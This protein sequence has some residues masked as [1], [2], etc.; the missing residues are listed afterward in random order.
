M[1]A[2]ITT[3][4][5]AIVPVTSSTLA[6]LQPRVIEHKPMA[7]FIA[8]ALAACGSESE[9]T[10]RAYRRAW[11]DFL[12]YVSDIWG[13]PRSLAQEEKVKRA[14]GK[15][16]K[17]LWAYSG[18]TR[19]F[20]KITPSLR[21]G[22]ISAMVGANLAR[23]TRNQRK[24]AVNTLLALA[25]RDGFMADEVVTR[26]GIQAYKKR[27]RSDE[28]PVG[29]RLK[30]DEVRALR[31][32]V[33]LK[34]RS[35]AKALRDRALLD[36]MLFAGLRREEVAGLTTD[37]F[38]SD[39]GRWWIVLQG[40]GQKTRRVK[41]HDTLYKSLAAWLGWVDMAIGQGDEPIFGNMTKGGKATGHQLNA[42]VIGRLV[43]EYGYLAGLAPR[44]GENCLSPH[45]LRR[46]CARCAFDNGAT[47]PQVQRL[48]G[49]SDVKTTMRYIGSDEN[50]DN[51]AVDFIRYDRA[52]SNGREK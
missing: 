41:L 52:A 48:L 1:N 31:E 6:E 50:D 15:A 12:A 24:N 40:K 8:L 37:C 10:Q 27:E 44:N 45:D 29:R 49:H 21:D 22:Y 4:E 17:T 16:D 32:I 14:D 43:A 5:N 23:N 36:L 13:L 18:D 2:I 47:L 9:N 34:A 28:K 35:E 3:D 51:T 26:L 19:I 11:G 46:T 42:S 38:K 25:Y 7:E 39:G 30:A 20:G 33:T